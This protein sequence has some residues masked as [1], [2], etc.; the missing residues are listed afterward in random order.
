MQYPLLSHNK[1]YMSDQ[2]QNFENLFITI[3]LPSSMSRA[4]LSAK[5]R[6]VTEDSS[7]PP[8]INALCKLSTKN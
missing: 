7:T 6:L 3:C 2:L 4:P 5:R 8:K 1:S